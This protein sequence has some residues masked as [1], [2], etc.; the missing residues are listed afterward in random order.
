MG[1]PGFIS[2]RCPAR[3]APSS[4][5]GSRLPVQ[6]RPARWRF[7]ADS[8]QRWY[9]APELPAPD[10]AATTGRTARD[11][12]DARPG[13]P[14]GSRS[15]SPRRP[16]ARGRGTARR[17]RAVLSG[18]G[19]P[20][21][22]APARDLGGWNVEIEPP[23]VDVED[24]R[25]AVCAQQRAARRPLTPERRAGRLC[26]KPF[27][28]CVHPRPGPCQSPPLRGACVG[29]GICPHSGMPGPPFGPELRRTRTQSGVTGR[30]PGRRC[31]PRR[32]RRPRTRARDRGGA[33]GRGEAAARLITAPLGARLPRTTAIPPSGREGSERWRSRRG[34]H[35]GA[36]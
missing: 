34:R 33:S 11:S 12:V 21:L 32:R 5:L 18:S 8:W 25:I 15:H 35:L 1:E 10:P 2:S 20:S 36:A 3:A 7:R 19:G 23:L 22:R 14:A 28:S 13:A 29:I 24:D 9:R 4:R 26:R 16:A 31:A 6:P 30:E 27:R 17:S